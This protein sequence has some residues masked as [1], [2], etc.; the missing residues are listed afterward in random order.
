MISNKH[1]LKRK[2]KLIETVANGKGVIPYEKIVSQYSLNLEPEN[3]DFFQ[4]VNSLV[5][6]S[7]DL[8]KTRNMKNLYK[9]LKLGN[10]NDMNHLYN[11]QDVI[12]LC[13]ILENRFQLIYDKYGFNRRK[14]NSASTLSDSFK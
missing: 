1:L 6:S 13:E 7:R 12:L 11:N 4:R 10:L 14:C 9:T 2:N 8:F 5:S 3:G